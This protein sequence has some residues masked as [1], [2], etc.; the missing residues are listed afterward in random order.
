MTKIIEENNHF[1]CNISCGKTIATT[2]YEIRSSQVINNFV[3]YL[4]INNE[5]KAN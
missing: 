1:I 5:N 2:L 3:F 4:Y